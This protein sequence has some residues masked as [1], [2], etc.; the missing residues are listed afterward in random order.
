MLAIEKQAE[1]WYPL[2]DH[3]VQ[4]QLVK[5]VNQGVR[6]PLVPAGRRSGKT[7][8]A[9]RFL[10]KSAMK[11]VGRYFAAAPTHDQAEGI[12]WTDL[13]ELSLSELHPKPPSEGKRTIFL[14]NGST[15]HVIGLDKPQRIEGKPWAGGVIDEFADIKDDAW[16]SHILPALNTVDPRHP[17]YLAW[18]WCI[19]VP[20]DLNHYYDLCEKANNGIDP[21]YKVFTWFSADILDQLHPGLVEQQKKMMSLK[22]FRR[23]YE[24]SF[25]SATGQIYADYSK[26]NKCNG[27]I[28]PHEQ[29]LWMHD[30]NFTPMSSAIG[31]V[32]NESLYILDEIILESAVSRQTAEE[33]VHRYQD[34]QNRKLLL[35]GDPAGRAGEKHGHQSDYTNIEQVLRANGWDVERKVKTKAPAIVDRQ[36]AVRA[37]IRNALGECSLFVNPEKCSYTDRGLST[38][39]TLKGSTFLEAV[40]DFQHITTALGYCVEYLWPVRK[41]ETKLNVKPVGT[42]NAW[43]TNRSSRR[44]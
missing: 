25:E 17:D 20:E 27:T 5:A 3:P 34:H 12:W 14:P 9:K 21:N 30:F 6:F 1:R 35:F 16:S 7:E 13:K 42:V 38:V 19:G 41:P 10:V 43:N 15:I 44:R 40:T 2:I 39:Q 33:F 11:K 28:Q 8:R 37:K 32:R 22:Q 29:L 18:C 24:A 36:N 23:E 26:E 31:V 4:S